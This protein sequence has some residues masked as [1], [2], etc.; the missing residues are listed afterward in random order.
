MWREFLAF[1]G[2]W[3]QNIML[4][5]TLGNSANTDLIRQAKGE[6]GQAPLPTR[7]LPLKQTKGFEDC[8]E[9]PQPWLL[10]LI[11]ISIMQGQHMRVVVTL[12]CRAVGRVEN[13]GGGTQMCRA[14]WTPPDWNRVNV[15][16]KIWRGDYSSISQYLR[17]YILIMTNL[18]LFLS[19]LSSFQKW[20]FVIKIVLTYCEKKLF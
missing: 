12:F 11:C 13:R 8:L 1:W 18:S 6:P 15:S 16:V 4:S 2:T 14:K 9:T 7:L 17:P 10:S 20:Y 19:L 5:C 3:A